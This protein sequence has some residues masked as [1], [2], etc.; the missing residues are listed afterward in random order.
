ETVEELTLQAPLVLAETGAV[1]I[2]VSVS[3]PGEDGLREIAIHSR[4]E[5]EDEDEDWALNASGAL[6]E[7]VAVASESLDSWPPAGA[8]P[9][10]VDYL[11]DRLAE[12]GLQYG[13]AFQG[14]TAAWRDS[15]QIFAEVSLPEAPAQ[16]AG[17]FGI[18][19][20]LLDA[21]LHGIGLADKGSPQAALPFSWREVSL[22]AVGARELRARIALGAEGEVSIAL[23]DGAGAPLATVGSL[24]LRP[25]SSAQLQAAGRSPDGLLE[26]EWAEVPLPE[27]ETASSEVELL[28]CETDGDGDRAEAARQAAQSA[29]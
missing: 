22:H 18:H 28:H 27:R 8:E 11:Y 16:E 20:A 26:L 5:G 13:P 1:A 9:L 12:H 2:Q 25:L 29:L 6:S 23:A 4:P 15:E 14:L 17:R 10:E 3:G 21:A 19:P 7:Q 24:A